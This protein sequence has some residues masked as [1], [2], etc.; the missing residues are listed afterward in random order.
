MSRSTLTRRTLAHLSIVLA[1]L[2]LAAT[3]C[4]EAADQRASEPAPAPALSPVSVIN[5]PAEPNAPAQ[6][7]G[8]IGRLGIFVPR[9]TNGTIRTTTGEIVAEAAALGV[10]TVRVEQDITRPV[11]DDLAAFTASGLDIVLTLRNGPQL[12]EKGKPTVFPPHTPEDLAVFRLNLGRTLDAS[13][14][15]LLA[16]ENE[17][18]GSP[19]VSGTASDYIAELSAAIDIGH[20]HGVPVTNGGI[21]SGIAAVL[22]WQDLFDTQSKTAAD[23]FARRAFPRPIE[24]RTL[25]TLLSSA[26]GSLPPG[27]LTDRVSK[28]HELVDAYAKMPLDFVNFHWYIDDDEALAQTVAYLQRATGHPAITHEIGQFSMDP[29][30]VTGHLATLAKLGVKFVIWFDADGDPAIGLH[31]APTVLRPTGAA[32]KSAPNWLRG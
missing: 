3:S 23:D 19:F 24:S 16:V 2:T 7:L 13:S 12:G 26:D 29:A 5:R 32:L 25:S 28:A 1:L 30:V 20:A 31:D 4:G 21:V 9:L 18:V 8:R 27:E 22:T 11:G 17:E 10:G 14:P 6:R 15:A